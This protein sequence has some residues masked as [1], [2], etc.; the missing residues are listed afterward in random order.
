M[1]ERLHY[2]TP[3]DYGHDTCTTHFHTL[4]S[5]QPWSVVFSLQAFYAPL[6]TNKA[7]DDVRQRPSRR[8]G[9]VSKRSVPMTKT[10]YSQTA[11]I[12]VQQSKTS[13][14]FLSKSCR[15]PFVTNTACCFMVKAFQALYDV[16]RTSEVRCDLVLRT[17]TIIGFSLTPMNGLLR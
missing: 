11:V 13:V 1:N 7:A 12:R 16:V 8:P 3:M 17:I 2:I 14:P 10:A 6:N 9:P 4:T 5:G 15:S